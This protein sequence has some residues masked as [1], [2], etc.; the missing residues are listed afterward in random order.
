GTKQSKLVEIQRE[1]AHICQEFHID[2]QEV[3][4]K[5]DQV[6]EGRVERFVNDLPLQGDYANLRRFIERVENSRNFLLIDRVVLSGTKE[7]GSMLS[8]TIEVA[9]YF[10]APW[11]AAPA[12]A[13]RP[14]G[15]GGRA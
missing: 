12:R 4:Y 7:S 8:L 15:P 6:T 11:L 1:I 10:D 13:K 14:A 5:T 2:P 9:T 3:R